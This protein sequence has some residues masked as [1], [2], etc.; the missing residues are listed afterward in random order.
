MKRFSSLVIAMVIAT[1]TLQGCYGKM[2]LTRKVYHVNGEVQNKYARS[3][4]TWAFVIVPVYAV[5]ALADFIVFN[6]IEF[7]SGNNLIGEGEKNFQYSEN[8]E[9][10]RVNARKNGATVL[11]VINHYRGEQHIDTLSINWDT[12]SGNSQATLVE[13]GKVTAFDAIRENG[14][15]RV[16]TS[17]QLGTVR[18]LESVA[19]YR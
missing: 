8:G 7:W 17:G 9:T 12:K 4:V 16:A 5:S 13:A 11:Y 14:G 1:T 10:Y 15:V 2:A 6:T 18:A 3:L 19:F